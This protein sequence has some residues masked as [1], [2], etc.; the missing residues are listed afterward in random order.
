M[1]CDSHVL[2][3]FFLGNCCHLLQRV[4]TITC[5]R[6]T[7]QVSSHVL[8]LNQLWNLLF[9]SKLNLSLTLPHFIWNPLESQLLVDFFLI[10]SSK[11]LFSLEQAIFRKLHSFLDSELSHLDIMLLTS[12]KILGS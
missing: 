1:I 9:L 3:P 8:E 2:I 6:V 10:F 4:T 5:S 12:H 7:M 11:L